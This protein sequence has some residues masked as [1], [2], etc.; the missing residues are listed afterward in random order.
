MCKINLKKIKYVIDFSLKKKNFVI[1][2]LIFILLYL[3]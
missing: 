3:S 2:I 1:I